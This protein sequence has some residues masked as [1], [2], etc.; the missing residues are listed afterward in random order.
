MVMVMIMLV[1]KLNSGKNH[2]FREQA[3]MRENMVILMELFM[4]G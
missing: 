3:N 4:E 2:K 1:L